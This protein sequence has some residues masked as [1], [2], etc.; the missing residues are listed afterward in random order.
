M[1]PTP[2]PATEL[3][4]VLEWARLNGSRCEVIIV[5][6]IVG[7][8]DWLFDYND[9][10]SD[11]QGYTEEQFEFFYKAIK[12]LGC[13][14]RAFSS[15][16]EFIH[17]LTKVF[18]D[19]P[20]DHPVFCYNMAEGGKGAG[21]KS[22]IPALSGF[23]GLTSCNSSPHANSLCHHKF[24]AN[25]ILKAN[26]IP[27]PDSWLY[28]LREGWIN[29]EKP[30]AGK[31]VIAK[32]IYE[33]MCIGIDDQSVFA[34]EEDRVDWLNERTTVLNQPFILQEFIEGYEICCPIL[35]SD[36]IISPGI[37]G[38]SIGD[39]QHLVTEY[40]QYKGK[41][42]SHYQIYDPSFVDHDLRKSLISDAQ[43][44]FK[45]FEMQGIGR[46]DCRL[47]KE[48]RYA[49]FDTNESPPPIVGTAL[50]TSLK[51]LG[52]SD[53][54]ACQLFLAVSLKREMTKLAENEGQI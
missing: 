22:L 54:E 34:W 12:K 4:Q 46:M 31:R 2:D 36:K 19:A 42:Q 6:N 23:Y 32:P 27:A 10:P 40:K 13:S 38:F 9:Y 7:R 25:Q 51:N 48:G 24:H 45:L 21:Q 11:E 50:H 47:T 44:I 3:S 18:C 35:E 52:F 1:N 39:Q 41:D 8:F 14:T 17:Y 20:P 49:F 28:L 33:S 30:I 43:K 37:V 16:K 26:G 15:E 53:E 29:G 5:A